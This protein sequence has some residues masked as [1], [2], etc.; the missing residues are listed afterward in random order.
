MEN[1][2][3]RDKRPKITLK[4]KIVINTIPLLSPLTGVG[5][6]INNLI[7]EFQRLQPNFDYTYYYGYFTKTLKRCDNEE[8][9]L[10]QIKEFIKE[11]PFL[12]TMARWVKGRFIGIQYKDYDVYFE[13]NFIP[14]DI[15]AKRII[16]TVHD[17]SFLHPEWH[18]EDRVRYFSK[19]FFA[20]IIK[21]HT[22]ITPSRYTASKVMEGL[23]MRD[24]MRIEIIPNGYDASVFNTTTMQEND[25]SVISN[26]ILFVGSIEPRKNLDNLLKAY[27]MLPEPLKK[28]FKLLL[29]GFKGWKN[30]ET[31]K[32]LKQL[33]GMVGYIGYVDNKKLASL[34][35]KAF[36]LIYPSFY[37]GFGLP[38]L[39]AMACGCPVIVS[40]VASLP[41]VCGD[42]AYYVDPYSV[43]SIAE[44]IEKVLTEEELRQ[45]LIKKG[46]E[47]AQLFSWEKSARGHLRVFEDVLKT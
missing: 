1:I 33:K 28:D 42:A 30:E 15:R 19:N 40:N 13:P 7:T 29:V 4:V 38:P 14:L 20:R 34:Y 37:E 18:P 36:C 35:R 22:I 16:T 23:R 41:E 24:I 9:Y 6:Y 39:E 10:H 8:T 47:R 46:L 21:S 17:L 11:T 3:Y 12:S 43:E 2:G 44:G 32:L 26:Y 45:S 25:N 5:I 27:L 31:M